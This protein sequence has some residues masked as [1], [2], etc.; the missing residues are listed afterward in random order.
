VGKIRL[1]VT[2]PLSHGRDPRPLWYCSDAELGRLPLR[3]MRRLQRCA[4][5]CGADDRSDLGPCSWLHSLDAI[6]ERAR[7]FD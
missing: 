5:L 3:S 6:D 2:A 7:L 4:F 1:E